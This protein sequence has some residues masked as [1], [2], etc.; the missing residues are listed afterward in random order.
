MN[1]IT[2]R[3][4]EKITISPYGAASNAR[5]S[6]FSRNMDEKQERMTLEEF[7]KKVTNMEYRNPNIKALGMTPIPPRGRGLEALHGLL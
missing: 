1:T 2:I 7:N 4:D 5:F 6:L 3:D